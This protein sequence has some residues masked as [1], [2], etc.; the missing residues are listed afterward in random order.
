MARVPRFLDVSVPLALGL[1]TYP[2]NPPFEFEPVKRI[3]N[4]DSSNVSR[5]VIGTHG[6]RCSLRV[7]RLSCPCL[8]LRIAGADAPRRAS[9][10]SAR[11]SSC[12]TTF[13]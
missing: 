6:E 9:S 3:A 1:P 13:S 7:Y 11:G 10:S 5:M 8:P 4:G 12:S 2:G